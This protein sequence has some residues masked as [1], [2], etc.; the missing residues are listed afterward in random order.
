MARAVVEAARQTDARAILPT[1]RV[2]TL[3]LHRTDDPATH[4][5]HGRYMADNIPG[6]RYVEWP[7][8]DHLP[9]LGDPDAVVE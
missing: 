9:W 3:V 8:E 4:V 5:S 2:P 1:I 6:A 7:G